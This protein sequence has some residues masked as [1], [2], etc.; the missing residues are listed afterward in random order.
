[1]AIKDSL[2]PEFDRE[3]A[4]TRKSLERTPDGKFDW[5][6]HKKSMTLGRLASHLAEIPG[7][8]VDALTTDSFDV[9][10]ADG[11]KPQAANFNTRAEVLAA[12]DKNVKNAR[13]ALEKTSDAEWAK[14]WAL[15]SGGQTIFSMPRP[16]VMRGFVISHMIHHRAQ[17]GVY[18]RMNEVPVP[19][20][21]GPSA[22]EGQ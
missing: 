16:A 17:F 14:P 2:L 10:P 22:D 21:Y 20:I 6:P 15:L 11:P 13:A 7:R 8:V 19:S 18:L 1:M 4:L 12:F 3:V 5:Q 9:A